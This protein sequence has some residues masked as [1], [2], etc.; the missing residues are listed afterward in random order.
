MLHSGG[1]FQNNTSYISH[2]L[3][4]QKRISPYRPHVRKH[5]DIHRF[6][7]SA[8]IY[9]IRSPVVR[10]RLVI[11]H[12]SHRYFCYFLPTLS[13]VSL[14]FSSSSAFVDQFSGNPL[15]SSSF[16]E[17]SVFLCLSSY[18]QCLVYNSDHKATQVRN[19]L[20]TQSIYGPVLLCSYSV[21][22]CL[23]P[24]H[25]NLVLLDDPTTSLKTFSLDTLKAGEVVYSHNSSSRHHYDHILF[26]AS[27]GYNILNVLFH[28]EIRFK[29]SIRYGPNLQVRPI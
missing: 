6:D 23:G 26:Q 15:W 11:Y 25:G 3:K 2:N 9:K 27:D 4:S 7:S 22:M 21:M 13:G 20:I 19:R 10:L 14:K 1:Y 29:A 16:S 24:T 17:T 8:A 18:W 12:S 28:V 5:L